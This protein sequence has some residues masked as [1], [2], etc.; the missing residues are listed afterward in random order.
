M[1][2]ASLDFLINFFNKPV[3]M[4]TIVSSLVVASPQASVGS[5]SWKTAFTCR[6]ASNNATALVYLK[7][8]QYLE[9][10]GPLGSPAIQ[11]SE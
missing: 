6:Y 9:V 2:S 7:L 11:C 1:T 8:K 10:R 5:R 4:C 3:T